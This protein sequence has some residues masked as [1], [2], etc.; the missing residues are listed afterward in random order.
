M[1]AV[2]E[3]KGVNKIATTLLAHMPVVVTEGIA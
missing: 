2:K 3:A 1:S